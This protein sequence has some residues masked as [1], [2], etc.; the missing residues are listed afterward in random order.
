MRIVMPWM[1]SLIFWPAP[2]GFLFGMT[3]RKTAHQRGYGQ[4]WRKARAAFLARHPFCAK[5]TRVTPA[6]V[7]DH[8]VPH[9]G[10]QELFW[11]PSNWQALC[12]RCHDG[13]K[14]SEE[15]LGYSREVDAD[16]GY[17]VD[18]RHP[19]HR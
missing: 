9:R 2:A 1:S 3:Q 8:I 18:S 11:N 16:T 5:C 15:R 12:K 14:Q 7:V 6:T 10:D 13:I 17:P 19:A 4:R